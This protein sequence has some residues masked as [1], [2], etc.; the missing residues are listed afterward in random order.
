MALFHFVVG[1]GMTKPTHGVLSSTFTLLSLRVGARL[2]HTVSPPAP[3]RSA[4][5]TSRASESVFRASTEPMR[6]RR[7][8]GV[9][10]TKLPHVEGALPK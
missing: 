1:K 10:P 7:S 5:R 8:C 2:G 3:S 9:D 6:Q 4:S